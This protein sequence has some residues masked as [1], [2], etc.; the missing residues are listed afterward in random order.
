[1]AL[2]FG[3]DKDDNKGHFLYG[4][5]RKAIRPSAIV[6]FPWKLEMLDGGFLRDQKIKD[7]P[8]GRVWWSYGR[9]LSVPWFAFFWWDRSGDTRPGSNSGFYVEGF[10]PRSA[11]FAFACA[12]WPDIVARQLFPLTLV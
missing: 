2:Y 6:G 4:L 9:I 8:D 10:L 1:V 5:D 11:S 12:Q 7:E 3:H